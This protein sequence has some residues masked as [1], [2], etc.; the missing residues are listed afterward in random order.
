MR[1]IIGLA[2]IFLSLVAFPRDVTIHFPKEGKYI[3]FIQNGVQNTYLLQG[4]DV[5]VSLPEGDFKVAVSDEQNRGAMKDLKAK[6]TSITFSEGDFNLI[7]KIGVKLTDSRG[8]PVDY[9]VVSL[10]DSKGNKYSYVL[11]EEDEGT[12]YFYFIPQGKGNLEARRGELKISQDIEISLTAEPQIFSLSFASLS[13]PAKLTPAEKSVEKEKAKEETKPAPKA[14]ISPFISVFTS[15]IIVVLILYIVFL[16]M[17]RRGFDIIG[18]MRQQAGQPQTA[19]TPPPSPIPTSPDICPYCGQR[20]DPVTGACACTPGVAPSQTVVSTPG[21]KLVGYEGAVVGQV[22]PLSKKETT[23]GRGEDRDIVVP[24]SAVSRRH[25]KIVLEDDG[26]YILDEGSTNG[27]FVSGMRVAR[28]KL[29]NGDIIQ[30]GESKFR[31][32]L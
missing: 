6:D 18:M 15:L 12:T 8:T 4:K 23:L 32:E 5:V 13:L 28:E 10:H 17:K 16:L 22:F 30:I 29:K 1:K 20:K 3:L 26:Y 25:C 31:F 9:A 2:L 11:R 24:D 21:A 19:E 7:Y 14:G 27:T